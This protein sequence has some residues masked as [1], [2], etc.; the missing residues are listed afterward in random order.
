MSA[1][2][3]YGYFGNPQLI[4]EKESMISF[5]TLHSKKEDEVTN[6]VQNCL[7]GIDTTDREIEDNHQPKGIK[8]SIDMDGYK[9]LIKLTQLMGQ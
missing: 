4:S 5:L 7:A 2:M 1:L 6:F 3:L 9:K 8:V